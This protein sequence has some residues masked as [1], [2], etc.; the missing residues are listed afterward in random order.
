M[1][2]ETEHCQSPRDLYPDII[3]S[4]QL[5]VLSSHVCTP[6][7]KE[8]NA[9][10]QEREPQ[11]SHSICLSVLQVHE[12]RQLISQCQKT[13]NFGSELNVILSE[14]KLL[15]Y[16]ILILTELR[17][18]VIYFT[19]DIGRKKVMHIGTPP[20]NYKNTLKELTCSEKQ[21]KL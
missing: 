11:S 12:D 13:N 8:T 14:Q 17:V 2:D 3:P 6:P 1:K 18:H 20:R 5:Y 19:E 4:R 7:K 15:R 10:E 21:S 9:S 16:G